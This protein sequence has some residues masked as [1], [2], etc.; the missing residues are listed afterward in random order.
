MRVLEE[1]HLRSVNAEI[2]VSN[3][4]RAVIKSYQRLL[5]C[6]QF[7]VQTQYLKY[8][9]AKHGCI[10]STP[11]LMSLLLRSGWRR[12]EKQSNHQNFF[13]A[14]TSLRRCRHEVAQLSTIFLHL[15]AYLALHSSCLSISSPGLVVLWKV[16]YSEVNAF[17][18]QLEIAITS[19]Q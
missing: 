5:K 6:A 8:F 13:P 17:L 9:L 14:Y 16:L 15:L 3:R 1:C 7:R 19:A 18:L 4:R 12:V 2:G 10:I 11:R